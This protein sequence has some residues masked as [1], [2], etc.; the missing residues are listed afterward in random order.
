MTMIFIKVGL[1]GTSLGSISHCTLHSYSMECALF[2][3]GIY[4]CNDIMKLYKVASYIVLF[5]IFCYSD[6]MSNGGG[7]GHSTMQDG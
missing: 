1:G 2:R 7:D 3:F 6:V 4:C 5:H